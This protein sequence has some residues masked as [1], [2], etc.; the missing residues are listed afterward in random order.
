MDGAT[1]HQE[2]VIGQQSGTATFR[3]K[4][5]GMFARSA[6]P[7]SPMRPVLL[8]AALVLSAVTVAGAAEDG[9]ILPGYW[10]STSKVTS[11]LPSS[12]TERKCISSEKIN[13][14]LTGPSNP[15]YTCHYDNRRIENG[16]AE[17]DG[18]CVDNNGLRSKITVSG[19][20]SATSFNLKG[21]LKVILGGLPI[22]VETSIDA[23]R[24][25]AECPA[26]AKRE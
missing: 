3:P 2:T 10:E 16:R 13:S 22:P 7:E 23:T 12:S 5:Q 18:E 20:Y 11:P 25:S 4:G 9:P 6:Y 14:Y 19:S 1:L 24:I 21:H 8:A 26:D 17:M 15:H